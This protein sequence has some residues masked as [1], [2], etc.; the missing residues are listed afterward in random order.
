[1]QFYYYF[2]SQ[3]KQMP[4]RRLPNTDSAR[5]R[6]LKSA[7]AQGEKL[8]PKD[9]AY[10]QKTFLELKSFIPHFEQIVTQYK[11]NKERQ[12]KTGKQLVEQFRVAR[13]FVSHFFQ[14]VNLSILRGELKPDVRKF[15]GIEESLKSIPEIGTEQ[16]LIFWGDRLITGEE[17]RMVAGATRIYNPSLAMVKV[18][19][20]QFLELHNSHKDF[21]TTS[22]KL[23]E[24]VTESRSH[25]DRLIVDIWNEVEL[26][27]ENLSPEEKREQCQKYG[28]VYFLRASEK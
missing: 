9:L 20:E 12:A 11:Q 5:I 13:L 14:V 4:Y 21:L 24:K 8:S 19:Y 3:K 18:K 6:A 22:Q 1:M 23:Q 17:N 10:S 25:A 7:F 27:F 16:Q 15:Y 2:C 28:L 26:T